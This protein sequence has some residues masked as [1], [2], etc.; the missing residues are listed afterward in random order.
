MALSQRF[1]VESCDFSYGKTKKKA[2]ARPFLWID[3][4]YYSQ[5][6]SAKAAETEWT[7]FQELFSP[8]VP[9]NIC[10]FS[11]EEIQKTGTTRRRAGYVQRIAQQWETMDVESLIKAD[12]ATFIKEISK[13]PGV[14]EWT[15]QM[16]LIHVLKRPK[17][18]F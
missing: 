11:P 3:F 15:V 4:L 1:A 16:L 2:I 8:I 6:I 17:E 5:Q 12:D 7:R 10:R 18:I 14:G 9:E 13:L